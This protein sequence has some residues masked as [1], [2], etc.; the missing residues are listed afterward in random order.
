MCFRGGDF[1]RSPETALEVPMLTAEWTGSGGDVSSGTGSMFVC[2]PPWTS[3]G[4]Q[5]KVSCEE[6]MM[7]EDARLPTLE[8]VLREASCLNFRSLLDIFAGE[9]DLG[10]PGERRVSWADW[11]MAF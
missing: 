6:T 8:W 3:L 5:R 9:L 2:E 1:L 4:S 7:P 11:A 10:F